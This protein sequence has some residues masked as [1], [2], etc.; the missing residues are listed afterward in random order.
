MK[1]VI[2]NSRSTARN[3]YNMDNSFFAYLKQL[4]VMVFFSGYPLLCCNY[5]YCRRSSIKKQFQH[6]DCSAITFCICPG[7]YIISWAAIKKFISWI[8]C[9]KNKRWFSTT[10][11][12]SLGTSLNSF[13]D[14]GPG[15]KTVFSLIHSL[16]LFF[17]PAIGLFVQ[18]SSSAD[19]NTFRNDMKIYTVSLLLNVGAFALIVFLFFLFAHLKKRLE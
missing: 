2:L 15:Q 3:W 8:F 5:F 11:I 7:G 6:K 19:K 9:R 16:V 12:N 1:H 10:L 17:F 4:E 13:L 18:L 14:T